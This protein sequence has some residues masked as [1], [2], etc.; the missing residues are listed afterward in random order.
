MKRVIVT[1]AIVLGFLVSSTSVMASASK[2]KPPGQPTTGYGS[3]QNYICNTLYNGTAIDYHNAIT[4]GDE[5]AGTKCWVY[6]PS[7]LK[8]G[9]TAPVVIYLH[10]MFMIVPPIYDGQIAHLVK[11]GYIVIFPQYNEG[12]LSGMLNDQNQY[13]MLDRAI[14]AVDT[15]LDL[16]AVASRAD[17]GNI[18]LAGHSNGGNLSLCWGTRGGVSVRSITLQHPCTSMEAIPSI[19]RQLFISGSVELDY[20]SMAAGVTC[21]IILI[22]GTADSIARPNQLSSSYRALVNAP[23]KVHYIYSNDSHG[24]PS[25]QSDHAAPCQDDGVL[26]GDILDLLSSMGVTGFEE[27]SVDYRIMYAALDAALDGKVRVDFDRGKWSDGVSVSPVKT[28]ADSTVTAVTVYQD[29]NFEGTMAQLPVGSYTLAALNALGI[30]NDDLSAIKV[31]AGRKATVYVDDNF[32]GASKVYTASQSCMTA[33]GW[34]DKISSIV[35][36]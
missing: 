22:G 23:T 33:D 4:F 3:T 31:P 15:A 28:A 25:L 29:C 35:V 14:A 9:T 30:N 11:Q 13:N 10:G 21:P 27:D 16:P 8:N 1:L 7:K 18:N 36:Q 5:G 24:D 20:R 34:N 2:P 12:G 19:V 17:M 6:I 32:K 26:P